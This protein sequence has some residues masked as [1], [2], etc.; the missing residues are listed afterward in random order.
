MYIYIYIYM[1]RDGHVGTPAS[2]VRAQNIYFTWLVA[3]VVVVV[4]VVV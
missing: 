3:V 2:R 1:L 4:V